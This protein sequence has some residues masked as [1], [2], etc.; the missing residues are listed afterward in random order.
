MHHALEAR[1]PFLDQKL[2]EYAAKLPFDLRLRGGRTKAILREIARRRI[3][4][5]VARGRKRGFGVPVQRWL[6]GRW[7]DAAREAFSDS[8]LARE[9]WINT[10]AALAQLELGVRRGGASNQLWYLF[11][12]ESWLRR[13]REE[14]AL[15]LPR[16]LHN[17]YEAAGA[18]NSSF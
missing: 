4:E 15:T 13:E 1:S 10:E 11:V 3:G 8:I 5:Q 9:G 6:A 2:W 18:V 17:S 14:P 16:S 7:T 12:L